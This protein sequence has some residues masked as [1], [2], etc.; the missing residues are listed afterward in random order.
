MRFWFEPAETRPLAAVRILA[1]ALGLCLLWSYAEDL[2]AWFGP[3]GMVPLDAARGWRPR[4]GISLFDLATTAGSL[5][6]VFGMTVA[7]FTALLLGLGSRA[8]ALAS[9]VLW[10]SL[11]H[12]GPM[13]AGPAD[14][15]L[16]VILWCLVTGPCGRDWSLDRR[17]ATRFGR[18][19]ASPSPWARVSLGLLMVLGSAITLAGVLAQLK[20]DVWWDGTAAW[21]LA[22]RGSRLVDLTGLFARSEYLMNLVTHAIVVFEIV[23]AVGIWCGP[24]RRTIAR[25][26]LVAWPLVGVLA[27]EPLWGMAMGIFAVPLAEI[28]PVQA[29]RQ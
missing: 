2:Q 5:W 28:V 19:V 9:A 29:D 1:A 13:L 26:A 21:W 22:A 10:A 3:G 6:A 25:I 20:G 4:F 16:A 8:A 23:F 12:R 24:T 11:L 7:A 17:L 18:P 14:D 27:G 15:C